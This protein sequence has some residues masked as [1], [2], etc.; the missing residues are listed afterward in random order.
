MNNANYINKSVALI[1]LRDIMEYQREIFKEKPAKFFAEDLVTKNQIFTKETRRL[2]RQLGLHKLNYY[3][4]K[5][6]KKSNKE[7]K[8]SK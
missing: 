8:K 6:Q 7:L 5:N 3:G 2:N 4:N 1:A